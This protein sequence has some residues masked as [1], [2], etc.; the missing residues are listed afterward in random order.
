MPVHLGQLIREKAK[1]KKYSQ[2][3]L[4]LLINRSKQNVAN[5]YKRTSLDSALLLKISE[6]LGFDFFSVYYQEGLLK[7]MREKETAHLTSEIE[8]LNNELTEEKKT[9]T[10]LEKTVEVNTK[11]IESSYYKVSLMLQEEHAKYGKRAKNTR[12][13]SIASAPKKVKRSPA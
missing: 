12:N 6:V 5:I 8:R 3:V 11:A 1:E 2:R 9:V 7:T 13:A 4:G 10:R